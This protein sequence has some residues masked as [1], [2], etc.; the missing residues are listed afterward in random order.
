M[1]QQ[2]LFR[3]GYSEYKNA[4]RHIEKLDQILSQTEINYT[5]T[6]AKRDF[7]IILQ[8]LMLKVAISDKNA[9]SVEIDYIKSVV[10]TGDILQFLRDG[11][12]G[13]V[14]I[15]WGLLSLLDNDTFD[16][17]INALDEPLKG[18]MKKFALPYALM[19]V[20]VGKDLFDTFKD[21]ILGVMAPLCMIDGDSDSMSERLSVAFALRLFEV[22]WNEV[23]DLASQE[24]KKNA[25]TTAPAG[26]T[27]KSRFE[28]LKKN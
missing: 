14:D 23:K 4:I 20:V 11:T 19:E 7:D 1:N 15:S 28:H 12:H 8:G 2:D 24:R 13:K 3:S 21:A 22:S 16:K 18:L 27:L 5:A 25:P 9:S 26:N 17:L 6:D 10:D